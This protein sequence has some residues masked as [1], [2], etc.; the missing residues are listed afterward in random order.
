MEL[1]IIHKNKLSEKEQHTL[2]DGI[3]NSTQAKVGDTGRHELVYLLY[4]ENDEIMGGVQ[5][6][7]DNFSWLWIDSLWVCER[8]RGQGFGIKLLNKIETV[9]R[10]NGCKNS[11]LTSF[12]Y[13]AS[14]F[15]EK[16]GYEIF[17]EI[18]NYNKEHS[19]C[20]LKKQ[21]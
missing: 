6:N 20:W 17:G 4:N 11:H 21:L 7:Y 14:D 1:R 5:G 3:E 13:Q 19:R 10:K 15:Y 8:L 9:A 18:K 12:S 2:W 16:Q